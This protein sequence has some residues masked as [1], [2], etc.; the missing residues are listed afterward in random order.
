[1]G[2]E[3][4]DENGGLMRSTLGARCSSQAESGRE[5]GWERSCEVTAPGRRWGW[6]WE[7]GAVKPAGKR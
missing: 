3:V 1:M 5:Q 2:L 7:R 4:P 6:G